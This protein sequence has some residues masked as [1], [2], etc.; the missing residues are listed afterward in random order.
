MFQLNDFEL[1]SYWPPFLQMLSVER[2][3]PYVKELGL[4]F[5][6]GDFPNVMRLGRACLEAEMF[7]TLDAA[8]QDSKRQ[9]FLKA[10][11]SYYRDEGVLDESTLTRFS[12]STRASRHRMTYAVFLEL[13]D[14][15]GDE[16]ST[17]LQQWF[18][19]NYPRYLDDS[20][21]WSRPLK[22]LFEREPLESPRGDV[23]P[24]APE[25]VRKVR[26]LI[27]LYEARN[28]DLELRMFTARADAERERPTRWEL[29]L[30]KFSE[31]NEEDERSDHP[32]L[33]TVSACLQLRLIR[34]EWTDLHESL[35]FHRMSKLVSWIRRQDA[36]LHHTRPLPEPPRL[37]RD[38][39]TEQ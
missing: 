26:R 8:R 12:D 5:G 10:W 38:N 20:G 9:P 22:I 13:R 24:L 16:K 25:E 21:L 32:W 18:M 2:V 3:K 6:A 39:Q 27:Q 1:L 34:Q 7:C 14:W 4:P 15:I 28:T 17:G 35:G 19:G 30:Q 23:L 11:H 37:L 36:L 31:D 29:V 33:G